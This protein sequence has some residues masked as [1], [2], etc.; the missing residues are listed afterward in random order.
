MLLDIATVPSDGSTLFTT[1]PSQNGVYIST[2]TGETWQSMNNGFSGYPP[3]IVKLLVIPGKSPIILA[4]TSFGVYS[5]TLTT[6]S[7]DKK[8]WEIY[9]EK[10]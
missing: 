3:Y 8:Q 9:E 10:K 6:T 7:V 2:D 4:A 5:Y 1:S